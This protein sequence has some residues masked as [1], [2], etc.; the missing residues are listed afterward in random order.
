MKTYYVEAPIVGKACGEVKA[1][2]PEEAIE[3]FLRTPFS[4]GELQ[5]D[6][7]SGSYLW[8]EID[9]LEIYEQINKGNIVYGPIGEAYARETDE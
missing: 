9:E 8:F 6:D 1:D 2:S 3:K 5:I 4:Y 7:A